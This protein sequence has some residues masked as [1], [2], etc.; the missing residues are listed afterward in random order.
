MKKIN[1]KR[2][3]TL[4]ELLVVVAIIAVLVAML[5]PALS[6]A[7]NQAKML[8]CSNQLKTWGNF[9]T[10][11]ALESN[12][13]FPSTG[14]TKVWWYSAD[15][16]QVEYGGFYHNS[17][18]FVSLMYPK[19]IRSVELFYC[20]FEPYRSSSRYW[21]AGY[22]GNGFSYGYVGSYGKDGNAANR[23]TVGKCKTLSDPMSGLMAD[24]EGWSPTLSW[25]WN[26]QPQI[27]DGFE[28]ISS[29][30]NVLYSDGHVFL[31]PAWPYWRPYDESLTLNN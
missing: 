26:H 11:Y 14:K 17:G 23:T 24:Q 12:D 27:V 16:S 7:R 20:P 13:Y 9:L 10:M 25:Y 31:K 29:T 6:K 15:Y 18:P 3:F 28:L 4:I 8:T 30:A 2:G 19:F 5:L 22:E 21:P 1:P